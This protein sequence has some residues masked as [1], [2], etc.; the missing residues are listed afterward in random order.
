M[1]PVSPGA[2]A[3][4]TLLLL[5][6]NQ[7][8][9]NLKSP[10]GQTEICLSRPESKRT[11]RR[12]PP[13][14]RCVGAI[15]PLGHGLRQVHLAAEDGVVFHRQAQGA[16][17]AFHG[18]AGAQFHAA[19]GHHVALNLAQNQ[20]V[21]GGEVGGNIGI[22]A[23]RQPALREAD[24]PLHAPIHNQVFTALHFAANHD[25]LAD[26]RGSILHC[27]GFVPSVGQ[28]KALPELYATRP[29]C[30]NPMISR[31]ALEVPVHRHALQLRNR[32]LNAR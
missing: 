24:G 27:H 6:V 5:L 14:L 4:A 26:A 22:G 15:G 10:C 13:A 28:N 31:S 9:S 1:G 29:H 17:I 25:G 19:A 8:L 23:N 3:G 20:H 16:N 11:V 21:L 12:L 18:A 7:R 32:R 2:E 30:F